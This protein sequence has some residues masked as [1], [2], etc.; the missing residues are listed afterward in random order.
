MEET[1]GG[2]EFLYE[3]RHLASRPYT[4]NYPPQ[5][6]R[7]ISR[8]GF[9]SLIS[10][11]GVSQLREKWSQHK[12]PRKLRKIVS[13]FISSSGEHVAVASSNQITIL[14]KEDDYAAPCGIFTNGSFYTFAAGAWLGRQDILGVVDDSDTLYFI[15]ANGEEISRITRSSLR[16]PLP[17]VGI[18][19]SI[20]SDLQQ[21][22]LSGFTVATSDGSLQ[23]IEIGDI[24]AFISSSLTLTL[25]K[26]FQS[27]ICL[28]YHP[29]LSVLAAV[30]CPTRGTSTSKGNSGCYSLAL[31]HKKSNVDGDQIFDILFDSSYSKPDGYQGHMSYPKVSIS[32]RGTFVATLDISGDLHIFRADLKS[33]SLSSVCFGEKLDMGDLLSGIV[34]FTWWSDQILTLA[35]RNGDLLMVDAIDGLK[36]KENNRSYHIPV[37]ERS[38]ELE[39]QI[40]L[41]DTTSKDRPNSST[42][43]EKEDLPIIAQ[44]TEYSFDHFD[45]SRLLWSLSAFSERSVQEMY[46]MLISTKKYQVAL[47]FADTH[48]LDKDI[49][50]KSKWLNSDHGGNEVSNT[51]SV[52]NDRA[53]V[54]TECIEKVG[55]TEE[56]AKALLEYGLLLTNQ[57]VFSDP[58]D[59]SD[60]IW[61]FRMS[62]L[63]LL[64]YRDRLETFMG[65]NMGRF[66]MQEYIKFR[67][68]PINEAA[69]GLAESGKIG[70]LNLLFKRHPYS[71]APW[72]LEVLT[73]IPETVA[74]Q[75]Y[76][77][78][79]PGISPPPT[80][81]LREEDWVECKKMTD[82]LNRMARENQ[83]QFKLQTEPILRKSLGYYWPSMDEL[84]K[85][86]KKRA[87]DIDHFT[88]QLDNCLS[89]VEIGMQKGIKELQKFHED[90]TYLNQFIYSDDSDGESNISLS[91]TVWD[92][93]AD[94][95][96]FRLMLKGVN[97]KTAIH[98]LYDRALPFMW[99]RQ[100]ATTFY[101]EDNEG[102]P[103]LVR[104]LKE[105]ASKN[106]ME[107]CLLVF[108]EACKDIE[109]RYFFQDEVESVDCALQCVYLCTGTDRWNAMANIL[110]K[111]PQTHGI[112]GLEKRLKVA[113]GHIEAGR[114]L[115]FYQV[116]KSIN[117]LVEAH[118][119]EKGV[120]QIFR[121]I[122]SKFIRRQ[123]GQSDNDWTSLWRDMQSLREKAFTF[124][125]AE[126]MLVEFCRGLLKAGK[127]SLARN[128]LK[129]T[130]SVALAP[131][132]AENL[133]IQAA[134]EYFFSASSLASSEIWK[135]KECLNLLPGSSSI[136]EESDI[137]EAVTV[138]LPSLGITLL[139]VQFRQIKDPMEIIKMAITSQPGAYLHVDDLIEVSRLLGLKSQDDIS[140]VEEAIAREAA[141]A[142]DL[143]LA[144][145]L[146]LILV[147]K[148]H[149]LVWDLCAAIARGPAIDNMDINS[150]KLLIGFALSHCDDESIAELLH[151]WKDLDMQG[152]C[153]ALTVFTGT[154]PDISNPEVNNFSEQDSS[155][156]LMGTLK[157]TLSSVARELPPDN[158]ESLVSENEKMMSFVAQNLPWLLGFCDAPEY[159]KRSKLSN[160]SG[161]G[162][163]SIKTQSMLTILSWLVKNDFAP[164][165]SL[166]ASLAK[167]VLESPSSE[168]ED[169]TGCSFLLNLVDAFSGVEVIEEQM[170][171]RKDY[172]EISSIMNVGIK[173]GLLHNSG[174]ECKDSTHRRGLLLD[175]FKE[176]H[177]R[178]NSDVVE[179][180]GKVQSTFWR[181]WKLKLEGQK[182][183]A[184]R[185]RVLEQII[186][187]VEAARFLSGD[188]DYIQDTIFSMLES[189]KREKKK[190]FK[191]LLEVA[192]MYGLDRSEVL[193]RFLTSVLTS[194]IWTNDEI[195]A[196]IADIRG[197]LVNF[198]QETIKVISLTVYPEIDGCNKQ[199]LAC[200]YGLLADCYSYLEEKDVMPNF[201]CD[202]ALSSFGLS[203]YY[204]LIERECKKISFVENLDFKNIARLNGLN[205]DGFRG[206]VL[207][208]LDEYCLE[209]LARM[210][211]ELVSVYN[212]TDPLPN[213]LMSEQDV[214]KHHILCLLASLKEKA[215]AN[216][217]AGR[218]EAFQGSV[219]LL[220]ET[221]DHCKTYMK[222]LAP[223][224]SSE[225][226]KKIFTVSLP[227]SGSYGSVPD[228]SAW[229]DCLIVL[230]N[231]F[232][233]LAEEMEE[234]QSHKNSEDIFPFNPQF[235]ASLLKTLMRLVMEDIVSPNQ[236]WATIVDYM[237]EGFVGDF[238]VELPIFCRAMIF[239]G[240]G[241]GVISELFSEVVSQGCHIIADGEIQELSNLYLHILESILQEISNELNGEDNLSQLL[242]SLGR[243][244]GETE[245]LRKT[246]KVVWDRMADFSNGSQL[247]GQCRVYVLE[248]MQLISGRHTTGLS[249]KLQSKVQQWE[250]WD[251]FH[252]SGE[253]DTTAKSHSSSDQ[254]D[255][256]SRFTS[257][258][259]ALRS[260]HIVGSISPSLE[261]T[262]EDL[263]DISTS[264]SC[265]MK[266]CRE[267]ITG[268]HLDSLVTV[269]KEWEGLF[270]LNRDKESSKEHSAEG[271]DDWGND[272]W[273]EGWESFQEVESID[274]KDKEGNSTSLHPL[275]Q[276]WTELL[277]KYISLSQFGD[278]IQLLDQSLSKTNGTLID[279]DGSRS[280]SV[281]VAEEDCLTALKMVL[282]L[283]YAELQV[284]R[285]ES[286][287]QKLKLEGITERTGK[288]FDFLVLVL[289]SGISSTIVSKPSYD[290]TF[291]YL[292]YLVGH[293]ARQSQE[294][295]LSGS[296]EDETRPMFLLFVRAILPAFLCELLKADQHVLAGFLITKYM[297]T[298]PS[299]SVINIAEASLR[300]FLEGQ[301]HLL[302]HKGDSDLEKIGSSLVLKN[303][304]SSF[305]TKLGDLIR[306][307]LPLLSGSSR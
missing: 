267:A 243:M 142:G 259:V 67:N 82:F 244:E 254:P 118:S 60:V 92:Q 173:Y 33:L 5:Q 95:E 160:I 143:Q 287:E 26:H 228:N 131:E 174:V 289:L 194:V 205:L 193:L 257:T 286:V 231:F 113:E 2:P 30:G 119:D 206:E 117:Y 218:P 169:I 234:I 86:Y 19:V 32:P 260:S 153:E 83:I 253:R 114:I 165:D 288:D 207:K 40:F 221:Y 301:L 132:K 49:V 251:E 136:K 264:T 280:L 147:R 273:D 105:I 189:L 255:S 170:R 217:D 126:Y 79:L 271:G 298:D 17:I 247:P 179:Q 196:E 103:Y 25:K 151:A 125:D 177:M 29:K 135:A 24:S 116:P 182:C 44:N 43:V 210:V 232:L 222:L 15:K 198:G 307:S 295:Q 134:R 167:S 178:L 163:M 71:L 279:E 27:I 200:L 302:E 185:T 162:Y 248:L 112:S 53:F 238:S 188:L 303:T 81:A 283:P 212:G 70:A 208:N 226:I 292:C 1:A 274:D 107:I 64:Q 191:D 106:R 175:L 89:L 20:D 276:C 268:S 10:A 262:P 100:R 290:A 59:E 296:H 75:T 93:L 144:F 94:Y 233:R 252:F 41:L 98:S 284:H 209:A 261:V 297:H 266:L 108:D 300:R 140:A 138:K 272:D 73:A 69:A 46:D 240:C 47:E 306:G 235:Q 236:A 16:V 237:N 90:I 180:F 123:P 99:K 7:E 282:L 183:V 250:G 87:L 104:W 84:S 72:I 77:Q 281:A 186:P 230:L 197:E 216:F 101:T 127:F 4:S 159:G 242:S 199:R 190:I 176:K 62:R 184:D 133:V 246:R 291:S 145:D 304:I 214:Y 270:S 110:S 294:G 51:L 128:Y 149:G 91:L 65:V 157:N 141:V 156:V 192:C 66:S 305:Q 146:C 152:Q 54:L 275:H 137:I 219:S 245:S 155:K 201:D 78:L 213:G 130:G 150:R 239:S 293:F 263:L 38:T 278:V 68:M 285:L 195:A 158:W 277:R 265:F 129:G 171:V 18:F 166:V 241:F 256:S 96:K 111:L 3:M 12:Q 187:G 122:L 88:G 161:D 8:G 229:Q 215:R 61:D 299:F 203:S 202:I 55:P 115:A 168:E 102:E 63:E 223:S 172:Q 224:H 139:P 9:F 154:S 37:L 23:H 121:L 181:E 204:K 22:P 220:E 48:G 14:Q 148:G 76:V 269:L 39:G 249:A 36:V 164:R 227:V 120:K 52:I 6:A 225:L 80:I 211:N 45:V 56:A 258:L 21:F 58:D 11:K 97:E 124:L 57:Y 42:S 85:W 35:K 28:D 109:A 34:D 31:W 50:L 74:V 13:L